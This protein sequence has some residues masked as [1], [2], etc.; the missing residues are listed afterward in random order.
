MKGEPLELVSSEAYLGVTIYS[1][2]RW[3]EHCN[4]IASSATRV[5]NTV[6]RTLQP[7]S[8]EVKERAY[9][10]LVRPKLEYSSPAWN[11]YTQRDIRRIEQVQR[12]AT[13]FDPLRLLS[14]N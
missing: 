1:G 2:L 10:A 6:R 11:P 5:L 8:T 7:C 9:K 14:Q 3:G 13:R 4:K 12:N